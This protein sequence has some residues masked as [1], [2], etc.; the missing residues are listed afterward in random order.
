MSKSTRKPTKRETIADLLRRKILER[1]TVAEVVRGSGIAQPV[2][3]RF[4]HGER[5]LTLR[6][7]DKLFDFFDL[8]IRPRGKAQ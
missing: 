2:L 8:E 3:H 4:V 5:D 7:A 1:E 6:T